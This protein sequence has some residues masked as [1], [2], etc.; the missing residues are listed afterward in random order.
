MTKVDLKS[1]RK[2]ANYTPV[3]SYRFIA[4]NNL[5]NFETPFSNSNSFV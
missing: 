5:C 1:Y 4:K 2:F 3:V